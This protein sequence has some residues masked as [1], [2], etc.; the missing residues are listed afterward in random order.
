MN[1]VIERS[2]E[3]TDIL[4][5]AREI[6][7]IDIEIKFD[8]FF[9]IYIY[10]YICGH[11]LSLK[12]LIITEQFAAAIKD[13]RKQ[14]LD[15]FFTT[16]ELVALG[17]PDID[18]DTNKVVGWIEKPDGQMLRYFLSTLGREEGFGENLD[19]TTNGKDIVPAVQIEIIDKRSDVQKEDIGAAD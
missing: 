14:I 13:S 11:K 19:I 1:I 2:R 18:P 4:I 9:Y 5:A 17:I 16:A 7:N 12:I 10:I 6:L 8:L 3:I 15:Q